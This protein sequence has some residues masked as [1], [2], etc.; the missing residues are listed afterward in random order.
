[1]IESS[2]L[3]EKLTKRNELEHLQQH[4]FTG[5]DLILF[6]RYYEALHFKRL[7]QT[8][9]RHSV[10]KLHSIFLA[11]QSSNFKKYFHSITSIISYTGLLSPYPAS[12]R[13]FI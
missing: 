7:L 8:T 13:G 4:L 6:A 3:L 1:M 9:E 2:S 12:F 10:Q 5:V 11:Y